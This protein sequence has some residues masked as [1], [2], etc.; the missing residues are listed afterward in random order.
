MKFISQY[1]R[2][3]YFLE[4]AGGQRFIPEQSTRCPMILHG[5]W[6]DHRAMALDGLWND[7]RA[8]VGLPIRLVIALVVGIAALGIVTP[9]L[10]DI[11]HQ[12]TREAEL[13]AV[14]ETQPLDPGPF[15]E[16]PPVTIA[17]VTTDGKPVTGSIV[18]VSE[19]SVPLEDGP[20]VLS[21]GPDSNDVQLQLDTPPDVD[22]QT[23]FRPGQ[24][25]GTLELSLRAPA[26]T[27]FV[28]EEQNPALVVIDE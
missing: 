13:T 15:G 12:Q 8:V 9:L 22:A 18:V 20:V 23:D 4:Y 28:D 5:L 17:V 27:S 16:Y 11:P 19:G 14:I 6:N 3:L 21:T 24:S 2:S 1:G 7:H 26:S 25:R 10:G